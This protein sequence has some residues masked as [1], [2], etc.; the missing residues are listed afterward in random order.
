VPDLVARH[1]RTEPGRRPLFVR[2]KAP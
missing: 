1:T 2:F